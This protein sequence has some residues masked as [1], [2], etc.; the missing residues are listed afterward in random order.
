MKRP[1]EIIEVEEEEEEKKQKAPT[2]RP[3]TTG[4]GS[5]D[6]IRWI[7]RDVD[8]IQTGRQAM[9]VFDRARLASATAL[10]SAKMRM[11][12]AAD[13]LNDPGYA[14]TSDGT[15]TIRN[16]TKNMLGSVCDLR[17]V[18]RSSRRTMHGIAIELGKEQQSLDTD[19]LKKILDAAC[20]GTTH[21]FS[22]VYS[23]IGGINVI[24]E[25]PG[26]YVDTVFTAYFNAKRALP[27][28]LPLSL[29]FQ[30]AVALASAP[31]SVCIRADRLR[32]PFLCA[33][34]LHQTRYAMC[35]WLYLMPYDVDARVVVLTNHCGYLAKFDDATIFC[36]SKSMLTQE[37]NRTVPCAHP[38]VVGALV[39]EVIG[40]LSASQVLDIA[41]YL[42]STQFMSLATTFDRATC[43]KDVIQQSNLGDLVNLDGFLD[44]DG[45]WRRR[46]LEKHQKS[47]LSARD[48]LARGIA[49]IVERVQK[50]TPLAIASLC[51]GES[52]TNSV[53]AIFHAAFVRSAMEM[54]I[55]MLNTKTQDVVD[56][57][58]L[59]KLLT[60][61]VDA[62]QDLQ[63]TAITD[64]GV[65]MGLCQA[66]SIDIEQE[67]VPC[68][69]CHRKIHSAG[70][71]SWPC[72]VVRRHM[73]SHW[74]TVL[75]D[76]VEICFAERPP[77]SD[78]ILVDPNLL[79]PLKPTRNADLEFDYK[80]R[81]R[82]IDT[83]PLPAFLLDI[84]KIR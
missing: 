27:P 25:D 72:E 26:I 32:P 29:L 47:S 30:A 40:A 3:A 51:A 24:Q 48:L 41:A 64:N 70:I 23:T 18:T 77:V 71:A 63:Q 4:V 28:Q 37:A 54:I 2:R 35:P 21:C 81:A 12:F 79:N 19:A 45:G 13:L 62:S 67:G 8:D 36:S 56:A 10:R 60:P 14:G 38:T 17:V 65:V 57:L 75:V 82:L 53:G 78:A 76:T 44:E 31:Q 50:T 22:L 15:V 66:Q 58:E 49:S 59:A 69:V 42:G 16:N 68:S 1:V 43:W 20:T 6:I 46:V 61:F 39:C 33:K 55:R 83:L 7:V 80:F 11:D 52:A 74:P 9:T 5:E 84:S 34:P 73:G